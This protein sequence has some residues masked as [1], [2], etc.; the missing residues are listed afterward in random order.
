MKLM[1][2]ENYIKD[3]RAFGLMLQSMNDMCE[4]V[5]QV[6]DSIHVMG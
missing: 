2:N 1:N 3:R 6:E 4:S 5:D